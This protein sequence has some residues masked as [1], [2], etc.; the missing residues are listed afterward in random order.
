[1]SA[2]VVQ[3]GVGIDADVVGEVAGLVL[4][5]VDSDGIVAAMVDGVSDTAGAALKLTRH[6]A[7]VHNDH[8]IAL[9]QVDEMLSFTAQTL[10]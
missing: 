10:Q 5:T 2:V 6:Q 4:K 8:F 3:V 7:V 9:L 1:M